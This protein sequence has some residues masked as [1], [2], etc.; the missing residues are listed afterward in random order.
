MKILCIRNYVTDINTLNEGI[1]LAIQNCVTIGLSLEFIL[2]DSQSQFNSVPFENNVAKGYILDTTQVFTLAKSFNIPFDIDLLVYDWTKIKPQPTNPFD[3]GLS[4]QIPMQW[5]AAFPEVFAEF[6]LHELSHYFASNAGVED[7]THLMMD[8]TLQT[9]YPQL[10]LQFKQGKPKDYYLYLI[11]KN[12]QTIQPVYKYFKAN[13]IIGL[14]PALVSMLDKAREIA[15]V[16]FKIT[17]GFRTAAQNSAVGGVA[18]SAH[19]TG[20]AVDIAVTD[21]TRQAIMRG[22]LTCGVPIFIEDA[23]SHIHADIDSAIHQLG[24]GIISNLD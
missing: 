16:P 10:F 23:K 13:E 17:S 2:K 7:Q 22:L 24:W 21:A 18:N 4:L 9:K 5:Y 1:A 12:M 20:Q 6:F 8:G 15:G 11:K 3:G 19:L 14:Q